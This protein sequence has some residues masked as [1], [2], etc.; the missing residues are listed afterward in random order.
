MKQ[1]DQDLENIQNELQLVMNHV[2]QLRVRLNKIVLPGN[3]P[4]VR[5]VP[6]QHAKLGATFPFI[7]DNMTGLETLPVSYR[8]IHYLTDSGL[9]T[10][11]DL[12]ELT[13]YDLSRVKN[14]GKKSLNELLFAL[15]LF[16]NHAVKGKNYGQTHP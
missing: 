6:Y 1:L 16:Q 8:T 2:R 5:E 3:A 12:A 14:F 7:L 9:A 11:K 13:S 15:N 10:Y 4:I